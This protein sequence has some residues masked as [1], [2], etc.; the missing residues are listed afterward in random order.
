[1]QIIASNV[2]LIIASYNRP[3]HLERTLY[4]VSRQT[5]LPEQIIVADDGSD[6]DIEG[7][8][9]EY[10]EG[11]LKRTRIDLVSQEHQGF[12][13]C[14]LLNKALRAAIGEY[15]IHTDGDMF[16]EK[17]FI[18][19]HLR[20]AKPRRIVGGGRAKLNSSF[21]DISKFKGLTFSNIFHFS[22]PLRLIRGF[23][24]PYFHSRHV[25]AVGNNM[26]YYKSDVLAV[27]GYDEDI[28]DTGGEDVDISMR[29]TNN[30]CELLRVS[31]KCIGYHLWH[32]YAY[33]GKGF[34]IG[35]SM[36]KSLA[37]SG[38]TYTENGFEKK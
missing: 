10:R 14:A 5:V 35:K 7:V 38:K 9:T 32:S 16:L 28:V 37:V 29:M 33:R 24:V 31:G 27:N 20:L 36:R 23:S 34:K 15:I 25:N 3:L 11:R 8:I 1:M 26:S 12:R 6:L 17:H 19:D 18:E 22:R 4:S 2:T 21:G 30:G 13:K